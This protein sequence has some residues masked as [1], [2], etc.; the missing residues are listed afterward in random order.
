MFSFD[1]LKD[2]LYHSPVFNTHVEPRTRG[3]TEVVVLGDAVHLTALLVGQESAVIRRLLH[4][5]DVG[6]L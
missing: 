2:F 3:L 6:R 5:A 4:T 1:Y